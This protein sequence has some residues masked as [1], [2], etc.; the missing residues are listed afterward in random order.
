MSLLDRFRSGSELDSVGHFTLDEKR[1]KNKMARFQLVRQSDFLLL[2][3]Q[4]AV[5][6]GCSSIHITTGLK[7][8]VLRAPDSS[9]DPKKVEALED[10]LFDTR[11][12]VV[13]YYLLG[14]A[15]N[16]VT[17]FCKEDPTIEM[18]GQDLTMEATLKEP[19]P[20]LDL[21]LHN[22]L[23]Y[24]PCE[25][26]VNQKPLCR[27]P[28]KD[29]RL[30]S[31][32]DGEFSLLTLVRHGVTVGDKHLEFKVN[33][34]AVVSHPD[35]KVDASFFDVVE[36]ELYDEALLC[37]RLEAHEALARQ[38]REYQPDDPARTELL[39]WLCEA[40]PDPAGAA[41]REC[42]LFV[43]ADRAGAVSL[44]DLSL[45]MGAG[46]KLLYSYH[47]LNL[48][49]DTPVVLLDEPEILSSLKK[50]F[51][52]GLSD[53]TAAYRR[54][55]E[56]LQHIEQWENSPRDTTLGPGTYLATEKVDGPDWQAQI[57]FL[58]PP[59]GESHIDM[60]YQGKLLCSERLEKVPPGATAVINFDEV[61]INESFTRPQGRRFRSILTT[62]KAW[63]ERLFDTIELTGEQIYPALLEYL[64]G[65]F[66]RQHAPL[67]RV[68][69]TAP[70]FPT[71]DG[72]FLSFE[73]I[74][75]LPRVA[76]GER[77]RYSER[78]PGHL[79]PE[80]MLMYQER[81]HELLTGRLGRS[82]VE[83]L[84]EL[85]ER[86]SRLDEQLANP[87][88]PKLD[89]QVDL[90]QELERE[91]LLGEMG[92]IYERAGPVVRLSF[93]HKGALLEEAHFKMTKV[94]RGEV[95]VESTILRPND[96][97]SGVE[98]D[99]KFKKLL[100]RLRIGIRKLEE[101]ALECPK[102]PPT[103]FLDLL[104]AYSGSIEDY[105]EREV[106]QSTTPGK[107]HNLAHIEEELDKHSELLRGPMGVS[108]ID[109]I[110]LLEA[111]LNRGIR[112]TLLLDKFGSFQW[113]DARKIAEGRRLEAGFQARPVSARIVAGY[114]S[115]FRYPLS[116]CG[117]EV[118]VG[119]DGTDMFVDC[120]YTKRFVC[121]KRG[122]LPD[123]CSAAIDSEA[124]KLSEDFNDAEIPA[125]LLDEIMELCEKGLLECA[126]CDGDE[127]QLRSLAFRYA[128]GKKASESFHAAF[129]ELPVFLL[130]GGG[131]TS[132]KELKENQK[133]PG[134]VHHTFSQRVKPD[135]LILRAGK[136]EATLIQR[137]TKLTPYK[138]ETRLLNLEKDRNYLAGL[139]TEIPTRYTFR[140]TYANDK[141]LQ[142]ELALTPE[143][144]VVL[145]LDKE[146]ETLGFLSIQCLPV[147]AIVQ[148]VSKGPRDA[149]KNPT[150]KLSE[151]DLKWLKNRV[152]DLY[153]AWVEE[154]THKQLSENDRQRAMR[155]LVHT[156]HELGSQREHPQAFLAQKLWRLPLFSC[157]DGTWISGEALTDRFGTVEG[158]LVICQERWRAPGHYPLVDKQ[159]RE[160]LL[161]ASVLGRKSLQWY[162]APPLVDTEQIKE[163]VQRLVSWG[164][165]PFKA[166]QKKL[167]RL[168]EAI[169][170]KAAA[171]P[172]PS[173]KP[174]QR[175]IPKPKP[176][177]PEELFLQKM[178]GEAK[179]MLGNKTYY[180]SNGYFKR[181]SIGSWILGSPV[182]LSDG[183]CYLNRSHAGVR[184]LINFDPNSNSKQYRV[185]RVL[186]LIHWVGLVNVDS[187]ELTDEQEH[188]F[189]QD[190]V[191]KMI[192]TF[193]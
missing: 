38:A 7:R 131:R 4:A 87:R 164:V 95:V 187:E 90:W 47:R 24:C 125:A 67:P 130:Q 89:V 156:K 16:A 65:C 86:L 70:L 25:V 154:L 112:E 129:D 49:L 108:L 29:S 151:T 92:L 163:N 143:G 93:M 122:L 94:F 54:K 56:R 145:G 146:G 181:T 82:Q 152:N 133:S 85:Q 189:L 59:G 5:A 32:N 158:P 147:W 78:L 50:L 40:L 14:V 64:D 110:V 186:L 37:V 62:L 183:L 17:P 170:S 55:L 126:T 149:L 136:D 80:T 101:S 172:E 171:I 153:L 118:A 176:A 22:F 132:I 182:Y 190:L 45:Q 161:L 23:T 83:D 72:R 139:K 12:E 106:F 121:R 180:G 185:A 104:K 162:E 58:G 103:R 21:H 119:V 168:A 159:S 71:T 166:V 128:L 137:K 98:R 15:R 174:K 155:L 34:R 192:Q 135:R 52:G 193:S 134:Y 63:L 9:L 53:S 91:D 120:H 105:R 51:P 35:F 109:R 99:G 79:L 8:I 188:Q 75:A 96:D 6:A 39:D 28:L 19:F 117:G 3:I 124:L 191:E 140:R 150:C 97:W 114:G 44:S 115:K 42:P 18:N 173:P 111:S 100:A 1:A 66:K 36:D 13:S 26:F 144:S 11:R 148:P 175:P 165:S 178:K 169:E 43:L 46:T 179:A 160:H 157:V 138:S 48:Q 20:D 84:R 30:V 141:G 116:S 142:A 107:Y 77:V 60:L 123:G 2:V 81:I 177:T 33:F 27:I 61:E 102:L 10:F 184:W 88:P 31:L 68:A 41:L 57:G 76:L 167:E 113:G 127:P 73:E 69:L 74:K